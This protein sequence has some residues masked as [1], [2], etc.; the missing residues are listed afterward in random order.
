MLYL[1]LKTDSREAEKSNSE[2]DEMLNT[3]RF[4]YCTMQSFENWIKRLLPY[5]SYQF[6]EIS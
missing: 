6:I 1:I 4:F 3:S 5:E 2:A